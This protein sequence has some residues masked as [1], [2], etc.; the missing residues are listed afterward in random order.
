M[1]IFQI[2]EGQNLVTY[3]MLPLVGVNKLSFGTHFKNSYIDKQGLKVYVELKSNMLSPLYKQ[4]PNY[5]TDLV[6]GN[7][8]F[9][10][11]VL[12]SRFIADSYFFVRGSYSKM[13]KEAKKII[14]LTST[15]PYNATMGS[16]S[17]SHPV[18]QALDKT[19][20]LRTFLNN[21]LGLELKLDEELMESP[22]NSWF[23]ESKI[24]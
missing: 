16:F 4:N 13:S 2:P 8:R 18:L 17:V 15:L 24:H 19:K 14:Y 23:I 6:L 1:S 3:Y 22:H 21:T 9:I 5:I 11:F 20:T 12:P 10:Q 7:K